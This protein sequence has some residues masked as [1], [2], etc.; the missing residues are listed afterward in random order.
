MIKHL[1]VLVIVI[2]LLSAIITPILGRIKSILSWYV[3]SAVTFI[4][5]I[6][7]LFL[8]QRVLIEGR[9]S[10]WLGGWEPPLGIEYVVDSATIFVLLV[11]TFISF[12]G[13][14]YAKKSVDS[15]IEPHRIS[16][17]YAVYLLFITG[18]MGIVMTG[19]IFNLYVFLEITSIAGYTLIAIGKKRQ[20]L[21]AGF[22]YLVM[23]TIGATFILLGIG[24]LYLM[25]GTLNMADLANRLPELYETTAVI[26]A[27]AI[28]AVGLCIKVAL[29]PLHSWLPNSYTYAPSV[30]SAVM[31]ATATKVAAYAMYRMLFTVFTPGFFESLDFHIDYA[32]LVLSV[33]AILAG[34][35]L[36]VSQKDIK[37]MLAYS[38][39][40][41]LGYIVLGISLMNIT[42]LMGSMLHLLNHAVM[43]GSL[44]LVVGV[45]VYRYGITNIEDLKGMG[46]KLPLTMVAFTIGALSM[47]GIPLTVG[48]VSKWYLA[49]ASI[50]AGMWYLI[51]VI[52]ISSLLTAVYFWKVLD[53]VWLKTP[54]NE[55]ASD[56]ISGFEPKTVEAPLSML[57]PTCAV[58]G[59]CIVFGV[60]A[61]A[62]IY[63]AEQAAMIL[64]R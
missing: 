53:N 39:V 62:P 9:I 10:Y 45:I 31:A 59:L 6:I 23:G 4:C 40:G 46:K 47:I 8:L 37:K 17:F 18:L 11:V 28:I 24:Y 50:E 34:S 51:P 25:T 61:F 52:M 38:S 3:A 13:T 16:I 26:T 33:F 12:M 32:F 22:N 54:D 56:S 21:I 44:F 20:A 43:K 64:L 35:I 41:Q 42:G 15:E 55:V 1:P 29:F 5:F 48:F 2:P 57:I 7:S 60:F 27:F 30:I 19:D 14:I 49:I 36:A 58:A 63:L